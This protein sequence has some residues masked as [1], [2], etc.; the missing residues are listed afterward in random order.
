M[1]YS[2]RFRHELAAF[3]V[4][5]AISGFTTRETI[6]RSRKHHER[7]LIIFIIGIADPFR[8]KEFAVTYKLSTISRAGTNHCC[9]W[10][11][12]KKKV[13]LTTGRPNDAAGRPEYD[14]FRSSTGSSPCLFRG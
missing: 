13:L 7:F 4:N 14:L 11:L 1:F 3:N 9:S 10:G 2:R 6:A 8:H 5:L 12:I